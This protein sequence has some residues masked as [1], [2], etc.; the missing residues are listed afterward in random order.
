MSEHEQRIRLSV[1]PEP[2]DEEMAAIAA[3]V[4]ALV[5]RNDG[6]CAEPP[7]RGGGRERWARAGRREL[8][9]PFERDMEALRAF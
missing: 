9:R 1:H 5:S 2:T 3:A 6:D 8:L 7:D 4:T